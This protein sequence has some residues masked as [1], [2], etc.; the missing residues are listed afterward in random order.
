MRNDVF[1][2]V[3]KFNSIDAR[4]GLLLQTFFYFQV[5]TVHRYNLLLKMVLFFA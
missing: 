3:S 4:I 5:G 2:G 1:V